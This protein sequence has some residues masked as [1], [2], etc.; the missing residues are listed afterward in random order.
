MT[1]FP[2]DAFIQLVSF[3]QHLKQLAHQIHKKVESVSDLLKQKEL[4]VQDIEQLKQSV[5]DM[6][7]A[8]DAKEL[9]MKVLDERAAALKHKIEHISNTKEY[10]SLRKELDAVHEQQSNMEDTLVHA[11]HQLEIAQRTLKQKNEEIVQKIEQSDAEI[12]SK[13]AEITQLQESLSAQKLER[14]SRTTTIPA[15]WMEKYEGMHERVDDPVVAVAD[16]ACGGCF[17][18]VASQD[19]ARLKRRALLQCNS[20]YRFLYDPSMLQPTHA[21]SAQE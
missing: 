16:G 12:A 15:E 3:D 11:W 19:L 7:K 8:V 2:F 9:E 10:S 5:H 6:Q 1:M 17:Y 13:Q 20:C 18:P 21:G 14:V 4:L